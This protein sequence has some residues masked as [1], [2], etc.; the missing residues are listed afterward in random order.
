MTADNVKSF[1]E[2]EIMIPQWIG[3]VKTYLMNVQGHL[4]E[5]KSMVIMIESQIF[6]T[7]T[8]PAR[9][10]CFIVSRKNNKNKFNIIPSLII[11][12]TTTLYAFFSD[13]LRRKGNS[14][15]IDY[16]HRWKCVKWWTNHEWRPWN[17]VPQNR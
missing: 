7:Y 12:T 2:Q 8:E 6:L 10:V 9:Q 17:I 5:K 14:D 11:E 3:K 13:H 4:I 16:G 1:Q 15:K